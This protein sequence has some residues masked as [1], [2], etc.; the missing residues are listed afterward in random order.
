MTETRSAIDDLHPLEGGPSE[1]EAAA[2]TGTPPLVRT[3][4]AGVLMGLANLVPGVSG[5][6]MVLVMGLYDEFVTSVADVTRLRLTR[7]NVLF[8]GLLVGV[9][10]ITIASFSGVMKTLVTEHRSAMYALFIGMTLGGAPMLMRMIGRANDRAMIG[11]AAGLALMV[12]IAMTHQEK[13]ARVK[14]AA[15]AP[16][17]VAAPTAEAAG[18][19]APGSY[20]RS[21]ARDVLA[22]ALGMSA[23]VLPGVSGA[24][25]LL[26]LGRYVAILG[27]ISDL[28]SYVTSGG[29]AGTLEALHVIIPVGIGAVLSLVLLS[30]FLKWALHHHEKLMLGLLLGIL[31]GA[32]IGIWP[33]QQFG[34]AEGSPPIVYTAADYTLGAVI[35]L[36]G[37]VG[38]VALSRVKK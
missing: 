5:G 24:Y 7:R 2:A 3:G 11:F 14:D 16:G 38:T 35:C 26:I 33:F 34:V 30:N 9:V 4:I 29:S 10:G 23:M 25:M 19:V 6:T 37:F 21:Y 15:T 20:E 8:L 36:A 1:L 17:A 27:A 13:P 28:K 32:V 12:V 31:V 18:A 22:G